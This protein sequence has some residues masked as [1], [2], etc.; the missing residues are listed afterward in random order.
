MQ[1]ST[2]V[3]ATV[4]NAILEVVNTTLPGVLRATGSL[5]GTW[6]VDLLKLLLQQAPAVFVAFNGGELD[7]ASNAA[8]L[9]AR[10]DVYAVV[11][12]P[13]E[14]VRR[15]GTPTSIGAYE[16]IEVITP[17]LNGFT[18]PGC[19]S[20]RGKSVTNLF[21]NVLQEFGGTVYAVQFT[22]PR[23]PLA[24]A[25]DASTLANFAILNIES[26]LTTPGAND[27]QTTINLP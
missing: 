4:E 18:V 24:A 11:K 13:T 21:S 20:L 7:H 16:I 3:I 8:L 12:E 10:F 15:Q 1:L 5:P 22:L 2:S 6:S 23:L 9:D 19:G 26:S 25:F 17:A 14:I 27:F